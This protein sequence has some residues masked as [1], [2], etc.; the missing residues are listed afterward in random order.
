MAEAAPQAEEAAEE[1]GR[2]RSGALVGRSLPAA[3]LIVGLPVL[4]QQLLGACVGLVDKMLAGGL[5]QDIVVSAMD[6]LGVGSYVGWFIGIAMGGLGIG[7]Q[8][9]IARAIGRG[10][11]GEAERALGQAIA[12]S[13]GWGCLVGIAAWVLS[14]AMAALCE[15]RG[16]AAG[17]L[18]A[19]V[20]VLSL[21][22]PFCGLMMVGAMCLTGAGETVRPA[23]IAVV[24]NAFNVVFSWVLSGA[25]FRL[26]G[27]V[28]ENTLGVD[29]GVAGIAAGT[30]IGYF[31]GGVLTLVVLV[32]GVRDLAL[33]I[34]FMRPIRSMIGRVVRIGV[35]N[36]LE[37]VSM[38]TANLGVL[39]IIGM[40]AGR[41]V[42]SAITAATGSGSLAEP[43]AGEGLA[44][45]HIIAV[46]WESFSFLPGFA[47]GTAAAALAGQYLGAGN[48]RMARR[49]VFVCTGL[50]IALMGTLGVLF[51]LLGTPLT[52]LISSQPR[53]MALVPELLFICGTTQIFFAVSMVVRQAL[54]GVGDTVW[55]FTITTVSCYGVRLP[56]AWF[57]GIVLDYGLVGVW[58]GLCGEIAV[59]AG[60]FLSRFLHGGWALKRV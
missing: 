49:A 5:P 18:V 56:A 55:T 7:G 28:I 10:D 21:S 40:I 13:F 37:G 15:L 22:M 35:P 38:W 4:L 17:H 42:Q 45:A 33:R 34:D 14:P 44:G 2:I 12:L 26:P 23:V 52:E 36:F 51:M 46:Q 25:D 29:L 6:G 24:V 53:H 16:D 19:Y 60:L 50:A 32:R 48:L 9:I 41:E 30:A 47:I 8:A 59:R 31:V 1:Q 43:T 57:F 39:A 3:I 27:L 20:R 11:R 58:I 54:R